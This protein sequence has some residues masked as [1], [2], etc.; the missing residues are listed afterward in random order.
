MP[1]HSSR[2]RLILLVP[3]AAFAPL[4]PGA[5]ANAQESIDLKESDPEGIAFEYK[6][7]ASKVDRAKSPSYK[8][9]QT[10]ANCALFFPQ[11]GSPTGGCGLFMG[12]DV[13][14]IGWCKAWESAKAP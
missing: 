6:A 3:I 10:C 4:R 11:A 12:K 7:D 8:P 14:A 1:R 2:R 5:A 13:A 9:G